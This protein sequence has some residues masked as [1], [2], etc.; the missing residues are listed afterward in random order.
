MLGDPRSGSE[1]R[2]PLDR[3]ISE[4]GENRGKV[5]AHRDFQPAAAFDDRENRCNLRSRL[6]AADVQ[7]ILPTQSH[8][9]HRVLRKVVAQFKF[10]IFQ[11]LCK[12]LPKRERV[13][14][15]LAKCAGRQSSGLR[16]L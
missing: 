5:T 15:G 16:C 14:A 13:L 2:E 8:G 10:W 1:V 9:T 6:W 4:P 3:E 7:P 11:K 12:F